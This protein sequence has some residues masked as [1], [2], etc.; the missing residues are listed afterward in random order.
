M[1]Q[2][3]AATRKGLMTFQQVSGRWNLSRID[4]LGEHVTMVLRDPRTGILFAGLTL[5]HFG[6][7]LRR[8]SDDGQTWEECGVPAYPAGATLGVNPH[9]D[10]PPPPKLASL[11]EIWSLEPGG[12]DQPGRLWAGTIPGGL[13]KSSDN[14]MT[15][16]LVESLWNAPERQKWF[17][18]GKDDPGIHSICVD[19]RD[20]RH[21]TIGISCG[22]VWETRDDGAT[23]ELLGEGL[24][25]EFMPPNLQFDRTIQDP[26]RL[27]SCTDDPE[28]MWIQHHN[29]I[30][31]ST[32]G[33]RNWTELSEVKPSAF[34][35]AVA[36]HP[37]DGRTAWFVPAVKD[38]CRVPVDRQ[39]VV[40]RTTNG[41]ESFEIL[42][43][44][45]PQDDCFDLVFRH[46]L[47]VDTTGDRLVMASSTGGLW[48]S[49]T[50]GDTW[51]CVSQSLPQVYCVRWDPQR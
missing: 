42:R 17:G 19:P 2:F 15:W 31:R 39:L 38:E 43:D 32:D 49:E 22:G 6:A 30:F 26:H 33:G 24:R 21:V 37:R 51:H 14:G 25:A 8:S 16:E 45:L 13:F 46:S 5:G 4:F 36:V 27:V 34:G 50:R 35:F 20:S 29:G 3:H 23:W 1:V 28:R 10:P 9:E 47:D 7:K 44:G 11:S 40:I 48:V 41:G 12:P 18:G